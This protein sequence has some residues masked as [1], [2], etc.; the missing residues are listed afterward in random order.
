MAR[1]RSRSSGLEISDVLLIVGIGVGAYWLWTTYQNAQ[2]AQSTQTTQ[3][4][5]QFNAGV[6]QDM[7]QTAPPASTSLL[8][9]PQGGQGISI[10]G[11]V[12]SGFS[13]TTLPTYPAMP[14]S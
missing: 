12:P 10:P 13:P 6:T 8:L 2:T 9:N 14:I 5:A 4:N 11:I 7:S 1:R 3:V